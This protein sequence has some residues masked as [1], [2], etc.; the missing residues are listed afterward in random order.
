LKVG[1]NLSVDKVEDEIVDEAPLV[2]PSEIKRRFLLANNL[3]AIDESMH[4]Y[5]S[6]TTVK[7]IITD[8]LA[9]V[10]LK[11]RNESA[12]IQEL[13]K[14]IEENNR[15]LDTQQKEMINLKRGYK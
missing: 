6:V 2:D 8:I 14:S 11:A 9:P 12:F 5:I 7:E 13:N 4:A 10:M 3:E 15:T 1:S